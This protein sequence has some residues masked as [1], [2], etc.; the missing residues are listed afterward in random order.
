MW[1]RVA[2]E[3]NQKRY[4]NPKNIFKR[5]LQESWVP[6]IQKSSLYT[7]LSYNQESKRRPS[8]THYTTLHDRLSRVYFNTHKNLISSD[9]DSNHNYKDIQRTYNSWATWTY[10]KTHSHLNTRH[11]NHCYVE[12]YFFRNRKKTR[13]LV[14]TC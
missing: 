1:I 10:T 3:V 6:I 11:C 14:V 5:E 8:N 9:K 2:V 13:F 12:S 4:R 7:F